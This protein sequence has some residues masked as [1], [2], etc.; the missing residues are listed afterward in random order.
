MVLFLG[1]EK[2]FIYLIKIPTS[3][4][5]KN[6]TKSSYGSYTICPYE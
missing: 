5:C 1:S 2:L 6:K 3:I 4:K